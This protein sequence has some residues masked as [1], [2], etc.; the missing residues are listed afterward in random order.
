MA[1]C[2]CDSPAQALLPFEE[3]IERLLSFAVPLEDADTVV[4]ND[5]LNRVLARDLLSSIDVPPAANSAMDGYA[6]RSADVQPG[7]TTTLRISQRIA[8]G[9]TGDPLTPGSAARIFT[10]APVP[11]DCDAVI[12]LG[13]L[14]R[15][16]M[17]KRFGESVLKADPDYS[18]E[19]ISRINQQFIE[20]EDAYISNIAALMDQYKKPVFGVSL[21]PDEK[22]QTLYEVDGCS[23]KGVF[24]PTPERAVKACSK[25]VEYN[26]FLDRTT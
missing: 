5:A 24:Y 15:R 23:Y 21:L 22:N 12:N 20:F 2:G 25:M 1:D 14:G 18:A 13:I 6:L 7:A 16:I 19:F 8:A 11:D 3:A 17:V 4:L 10:G 9:E 26:R